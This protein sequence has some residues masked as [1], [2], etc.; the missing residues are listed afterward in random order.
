MSTLIDQP[1]WLFGITVSASRRRTWHIQ[2]SWS[3]K[4]EHGS[5][6]YFS[7]GHK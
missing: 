1:W 5:W 6:A 2:T 4:Y 3:A 7:F